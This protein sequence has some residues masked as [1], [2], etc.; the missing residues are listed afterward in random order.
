MPPR[1]DNSFTSNKMAKSYGDMNIPNL[2]LRPT[3]MSSN[4]EACHDKLMQ[5]TQMYMDQSKVVTMVLSMMNL[6]LQHW[7]N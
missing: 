4:L 6:K 2:D 7:V 1:G 3:S 5:T